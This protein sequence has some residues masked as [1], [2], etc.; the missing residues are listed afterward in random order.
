[1]RRH[2]W[3]AGFAGLPPS[4][5]LRSWLVEPG[6]LTARCQGLARMFR[7]RV[8]ACARAK[9]LADEQVAS[10]VTVR[11]VLLECDGVPVIFAHT[12]LSTAERGRL[13]R[14]LKGLGSRSLGSLLFSHPGFRRGPIEFCRIDARD[15]LY[16]LAA[17]HAPAAGPWLWARR[18]RHGL[19]G[20]Q[21]LVTEVFLP[22]IL[23]LP[24]AGK[25]AA[26]R[27]LPA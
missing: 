2:R 16:R 13:A 5:A 11:E 22:A 1:M 21:V 23:D 3:R 12:T 6:S 25:M 20:Q 10:Q 14:W 15:P 19:D 8:L 18:S 9:A 26:G 7:I 17:A 24:M 4:W 27:Q